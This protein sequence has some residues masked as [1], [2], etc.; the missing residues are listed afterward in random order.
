MRDKAFTIASGLR[1]DD[2]QRE[3]VAVICKSFD[4][5]STCSGASGSFFMCV[6]FYIINWTD[7]KKNKASTPVDFLNY[8]AQNLSEWIQNVHFQETHLVASSNAV[9]KND[10][11][12]KWFLTL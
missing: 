1:Y 6:C 7:K 10:L 12:C 11:Y 3:L 2:Y 5:K 4:K 9:D 8:S